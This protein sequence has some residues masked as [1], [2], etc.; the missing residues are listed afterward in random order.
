MAERRI[1]QWMIDAARDISH[2]QE[3]GKND[4][5]L[6]NETT[7]EVA[8]KIAMH[9]LTVRDRDTGSQVRVN[10]DKVGA[11]LSEKLAL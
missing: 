4:C 9:A 2:V 8:A 7:Q 11:Y 10:L 5:I 1:E 6:C 3:C